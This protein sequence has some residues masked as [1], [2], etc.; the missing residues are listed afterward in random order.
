MSYSPRG[1]FSSATLRGVRLRKP[2]DIPHVDTCVLRGLGIRDAEDIPP[3]WLSKSSVVDC[4][5]TGCGDSN[6]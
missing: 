3:S 2:S 5:C 1:L 6:A 4:I